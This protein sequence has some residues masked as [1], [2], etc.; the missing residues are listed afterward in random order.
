MKIDA[1]KQSLDFNMET[2][3]AAARGAM[4]DRAEEFFRA[5]GVISLSDFAMLSDESVDVLQEAKQNIEIDNAVI[6]AIATTQNGF[7]I[8]ELMKAGYNPAITMRL[9]QIADRI[10]DNLKN[11]PLREMR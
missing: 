6:R 1:F 9:C 8:L 7:Q 3:S 10:E 11:R 5:G 2:S 4:L